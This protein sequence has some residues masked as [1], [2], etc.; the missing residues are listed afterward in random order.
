MTEYRFD[1]DRTAAPGRI[2]I[3]AHNA[4]AVPHELTV[5]RLPDDFTGT[6]E[7]G[8][9]SG[10]GLVVSTTAILFRRSPGEDG[11]FALDLRPGR[12]AF[13]CFLADQDGIQHQKKG[14][15]SELAVA[16]VVR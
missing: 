1:H 13:I 9:Q 14:M 3:R 16:P 11:V 5:A 2:V 10:T 8:V 7:G 15:S 6:V 4:G 12:Y